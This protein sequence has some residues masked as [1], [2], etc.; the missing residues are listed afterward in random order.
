M[1]KK[2]RLIIDVIFSLSL[3]FFC[4]VTTFRPYIVFVTTALE[5]EQFIRV[6]HRYGA[7]IIIIVGVF[8]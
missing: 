6:S 3:I 7:V 5:V 8:V 2:N 1:R 4:Y